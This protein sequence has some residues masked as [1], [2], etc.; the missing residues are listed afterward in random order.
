MAINSLIVAQ[1][2]S[3]NAYNTISVDA[4]LSSIKNI[5][6]NITNVAIYLRSSNKNN[7][8]E[9]LNELESLDIEMKVQIIETFIDELMIK[10][11]SVKIALFGIG[12]VLHKIKDD[13][14]LLHDSINYHNSKWFSSWRTFDY[15][16][17][18]LNIKKNNAL[19]DNRFDMLIKI[20]SVISTK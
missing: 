1:R 19:L 17:M 2:F 13:Y 11:E 10:N 7:M 5:C 16:V 14:A 8:T 4:L 20:A 12:F 15:N 9:L 6:K 18:L 3:S